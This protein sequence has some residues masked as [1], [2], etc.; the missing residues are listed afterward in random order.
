MR[1]I[2]SLKRTVAVLLGFVAT[3]G[4]AT[5]LHDYKLQDSLA[6][7]RGGPDLV[8]LGGVLSSTGY[9]F[10]G[11]HGLSLSGALL[12]P[13][14][15]SI[16]MDF[17]FAEL[18]S[19]RKILDMHNRTTDSGFYT[20]QSALVYYAVIAAPNQ[21]LS[22]NVSATVLL[23]RSASTGTLSAYVDGVLQFSAVDTVDQAIF[24]GP[25][26]IIHFFTDDTKVTGDDPTGTVHRIRIYDGAVTSKQAG[27]LDA[28]AT[29]SPEPATVSLLGVALAGL[30]VAR[31]IKRS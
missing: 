26:N 16:A 11:G 15:Y 14:D 20:L 29:T 18:A 23:T 2:P 27:D 1:S 17:S 24:D 7:F 6:D 12:R 9:A 5:I 4:A 30:A 22:P 10:T 3:T 19:F 21:I 28:I 25:G 8:G 13:G 31:G